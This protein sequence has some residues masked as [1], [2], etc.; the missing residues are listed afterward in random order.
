MIARLLAWSTR[1]VVGAA[2]AWFGGF[3]WY[4][5]ILPAPKVEPS[6]AEGIVVLTGTP[7]RLQGGFE[8]LRAGKAKRMLI[9]GVAQGTSPRHL[10]P[11]L[12][13]DPVLAACCV[14]LG[15][16][17]RDTNGNAIEAAAWAARQGYRNLIL[18]TS[19]YHGPR[20]LVVF[21]RAL[22][23]ATLAGYFIADTR[24]PL[25]SWWRSAGVARLLAAE[26]SKYAVALVRARFARWLG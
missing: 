10:T 25:G 17:A 3:L 20:S 21:R 6:E 5:S 26:Y 19:V 4:V 14:D 7:E 8:I 1:L 18:V 9:S 22:P 15:S 13:A 12:G 16:E 24:E 11:I 2:L 23:E